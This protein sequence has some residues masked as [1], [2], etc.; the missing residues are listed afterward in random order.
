MSYVTHEAGAENRE[1]RANLKGEKEGNI[2]QF[3]LI[4]KNKIM[5]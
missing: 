2:R 4:N 3:N 1:R 5:H